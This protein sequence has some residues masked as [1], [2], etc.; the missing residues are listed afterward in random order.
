MEEHTFRK[1]GPQKIQMD[2]GVAQVVAYLPSLHQALSSNQYCQKKKKI[3]VFELEHG[4]VWFLK[5][6]IILKFSHGA[7]LYVLF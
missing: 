7:C 6:E 2:S 3:Q 5:K 4:L 1:G